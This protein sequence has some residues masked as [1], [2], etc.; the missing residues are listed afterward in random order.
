MALDDIRIGTG[1]NCQLLPPEA[2]PRFEAVARL[3]CTF[4]DE[5]L[6]SWT[7]DKSTLS[8]K[9]GSGTSLDSTGPKQPVGGKGELQLQI[10]LLLACETSSSIV[11][12]S[13]NSLD[14]KIHLDS[15]GP[16]QP[17]GGKGELQLQIILLL[18]CETPSSIVAISRNSLAHTIHLDSTG[19]KQPVGG[20][21][22]LQFRMTLLLA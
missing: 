21:G 18:A 19:P 16:K 11:A 6:C 22:E 14:H 5:T 7:Q 10:T 1:E 9:F 13:R 3:A 8:W 12:I 4:D 17:V 15:T 20:K 2:D